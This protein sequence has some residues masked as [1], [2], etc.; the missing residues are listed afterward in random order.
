MGE[1]GEFSR[2]VIGNIDYAIGRD[3]RSAAE[4]FTAAGMSKNYFYTRMRGEKPFNT[5]DVDELAAALGVDPFELMLGR[6]DNV[7]PLRRDDVGRSR[8]NLGAVARPADPEPTDE[9]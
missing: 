9:Q 6:R 8:D 5:N 7:T 4:I 2:R 1:A 3:P